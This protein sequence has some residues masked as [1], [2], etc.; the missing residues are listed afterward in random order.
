MN[1][2]KKSMLVGGLVV[3]AL[4]FCANHATAQG[5]NFDPQEIKDR[6][7][8]GAQDQ[9]EITNN[10]E[11]KAIRPL[12]AKVVDAEFDAFAMRTGGGMFGGG[13]RRN[14]D[15]NNNNGDQPQR[16]RRNIFGE[17]NH[18][19]TDLRDAIDK[20]ASDADL[21]AKV[22]AVRTETKAKEDALDAAQADLKSVLTVRQ[23]AIAVSIGLLK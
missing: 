13:R 19:I 23:E 6:R 1:I 12:V 15:D 11:W 16:P 18:T 7:I 22:A 4:T 8:D 5:R 3:A 14:N 17:P 10:E 9:L 20:K 2:F 21:K